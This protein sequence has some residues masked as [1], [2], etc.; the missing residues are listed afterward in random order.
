MYNRTV[1]YSELEYN[2]IASA[3]LF[4]ALGDGED[5]SRKV[6]LMRLYLAFLLKQEDPD[7][8]ASRSEIDFEYVLIG[9]EKEEQL[10]LQN[11]GLNDLEII[12]ISLD[13]DFFTVE[14]AFT[15]QLGFGGNIILNVNFDAVETGV[16]ESQLLIVTN[17]PDTPE[18][19]IPIS[20]NSFEPQ[21]ISVEPTELSFAVG[22]NEIQ[23]TEL[24]IDNLGGGILDYQ[25]LIYPVGESG[26]RADGGPDQFGHYWRDSFTDSG[27][28][29]EW[30]D[31]SQIGDNIGIV[32][33]NSHADIQLP[34]TFYFYENSYDNIA[35]S[36]NGYLT[37]GNNADDQSNDQ[38]PFVIDPDNIIAPMWD[39]LTPGIGTAHSYFDTDLQRFIIQYTNW[40]FYVSGGLSALT[41]QVQLYPNGDIIF[42]YDLLE[43]DLTSC[44]VGIE[45]YNASDGLQVAYNEDYLQGT[46][47]VEI[48]FQ[49][50]WLQLDQYSGSVTNNDP[51]Q[52][53]LT[54]DS[55]D[56]APG[57]YYAEIQIHSNDTHNP[58]INI[59]VTLNIDY[60]DADDDVI[61]DNIQLLGNY[62]NPFNPST[63]I[64]FLLSEESA[65]NGMDL[66]I[67]NVKGQ[68][69]RH[70]DQYSEFSQIS[71]EQ[72]KYN[73]IWNG[74]DDNGLPVTSGVYFYKLQTGEFQTAR[75]MLLIK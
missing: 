39:Y 37:F 63:V 20:V 70:F 23:E 38:I 48:F 51:D 61:A 62:P 11:S 54:V 31:I 69:I 2:A 10:I 36:S 53:I 43:G 50:D 52:L 6:D 26:N 74:T 72:N 34:F 17:D 46:M 56:L 13:N 7:V 59:P 47:A 12:S 44:T 19:S 75:K 73:V 55:S 3:A 58:Q 25:V 1:A 5:L 41:F 22:E 9:N 66:S 32:D 68:R 4:G 65:Q 64:S 71:G 60:V 15:G 16:F 67:Y 40:G 24:T 29:F 49:P 14:P 35:V 28:A 8:W 18:L 21:M 27:P 30:F 45:N 42:V 33:V 57:M